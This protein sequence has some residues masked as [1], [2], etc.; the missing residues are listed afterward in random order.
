MKKEKMTMEKI[1]LYED[2]ETLFYCTYH[3][4][5]FTL[6]WTELADAMDNEQPFPLRYVGGVPQETSAIS[7][8]KDCPN[9]RALDAWV[10]AIEHH[11]SAL[12]KEDAE[13]TYTP[14]TS[15]PEKPRRRR[16]RRRRSH[17]SAAPT[18][19]GTAPSAAPNTAPGT[20]PGT[21]DG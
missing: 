7:T 11:L 21:G 15:S 5:V 2:G 13:R 10:E 6:T 3:G 14:P 16:R 9:T 19:A 20:A 17:T 4:A 12:G 8:K 18:A 1:G